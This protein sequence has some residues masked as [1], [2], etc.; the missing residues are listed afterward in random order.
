M[1][2]SELKTLFIEWVSDINNMTKTMRFVYFWVKYKMPEIDENRLR[3]FTNKLY[4]STLIPSFF[5]ENPA[6]AAIRQL[7]EIA[8]VEL[9]VNAIVKTQDYNQIIKYY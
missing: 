9:E 3:E 6:I 1:D 2:K 8:R 7:L 4:Q 5:N